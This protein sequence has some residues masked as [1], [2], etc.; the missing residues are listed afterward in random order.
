MSQT[1]SLPS[2]TQVLNNPQQ[3]EQL[4]ERVY[5][6]MQENL[7]HQQEQLKSYASGRGWA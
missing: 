7:R 2:V 4:T 3:L 6:L 1:S 5:V